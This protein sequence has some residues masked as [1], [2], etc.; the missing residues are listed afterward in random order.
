MSEFNSSSPSQE[1]EITIN[2]ET[3][4]VA[5]HA[6]LDHIYTAWYRTQIPN[7]PESNLKGY[8]ASYLLNLWSDYGNPIA[9]AHL[10]SNN[11][12]PTSSENPTGAKNNIAKA[13]K[14]ALYSYDL[15][16]AAPEM[17]THLQKPLYSFYDLLTEADWYDPNI[18]YG[19]IF[20]A[21]RDVGT[22]LYSD[23][24]SIS[25]KIPMEIEDMY[26]EYE[27]TDPIYALLM[28]KHTVYRTTAL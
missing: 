16:C 13:K 23:P 22:I 3:F 25:P 6:F 24:A 9:A 15:I 20:P 11:L 7:Y 26:R 19:H 5:G 18:Y 27:A 8:I 28:K 21:L 10:S 17:P 14:N 4:D 1:T 2:G 12:Q